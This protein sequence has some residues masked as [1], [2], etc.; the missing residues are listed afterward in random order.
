MADRCP[1]AAVSHDGASG[2][3]RFRHT[4]RVC[5]C[6]GGWHRA[7]RPRGRADA[8]ENTGNIIHS[9]FDTLAGRVCGRPPDPAHF[10]GA[11]RLDGRFPHP[12][13]SRDG[14]LVGHGCRCHGRHRPQAGSRFGH[15]AEH[16]C[17]C[18][19][20]DGHPFIHLH[21]RPH[22]GC[23]A[24]RGGRLPRA[25]DASAG[26]HPSHGV[27]APAP[28]YRVAGKSVAGPDRMG[29]DCCGHGVSGKVPD[30]TAY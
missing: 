8:Y 29:S 17:T 23:G 16:R 1:E 10:A 5:C 2:L 24:C 11:Q 15:T 18:P 14:V 9:N 22:R 20:Y 30:E 12:R 25:A 6:C 4:C 3:L 7:C 26:G 19:P 21:P 27:P 28:G 13:L